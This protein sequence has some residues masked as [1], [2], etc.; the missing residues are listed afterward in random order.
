MW[1]VLFENGGKRK[2]S[3]FSTGRRKV[4]VLVHK[5][6]QNGVP[7]YK[8]HLKAVWELVDTAS[9]NELMR[10]FSLVNYCLQIID[11]YTGK[12]AGYL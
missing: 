1:A 8:S 5:V 4:E 3:K 2:H 6:A 7:P 9:R 11:P 10:F 12:S